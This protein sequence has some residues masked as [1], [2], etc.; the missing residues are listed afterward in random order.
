MNEA[1][2]AV[3]VMA[4]IPDTAK[5]FGLSEHFTRTLVWQRKIKF[6]RAGKKYLINEKSLI[7]YLNKGEFD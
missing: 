2:N 3:P 7:E 4:S 1:N 5:K 6:V